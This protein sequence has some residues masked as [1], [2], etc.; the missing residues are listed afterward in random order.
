MYSF[1]Y[2]LFK[3]IM[4]PESVTQTATGPKEVS[5]RPTEVGWEIKEGTPLTADDQFRREIPRHVLNSIP[6]DHQRRGPATTHFWDRVR[7][8][9]GYQEIR[10][11]LAIIES[12]GFSPEEVGRAVKV[13]RERVGGGMSGFVNVKKGKVRESLDRSLELGINWLADRLVLS[14]D[15]FVAL[16]EAFINQN[17]GIGF[18]QGGV[19]I[20]EVKRNTDL[21]EFAKG[22]TERFV[23][24]KL[25]QIGKYM[26]NPL[27]QFSLSSAD[28][29]DMPIKAATS[30]APY[31]LSREAYVNLEYQDSLTGGNM[32]MVSVARATMGMLEEAVAFV[33]SRGNVAVPDFSFV[34]DFDN[35]SRLAGK[36]EKN[37]YNL[38]K[39]PRSERKKYYDEIHTR[40][41]ETLA[42]ALAEVIETRGQL[43]P[44]EQFPLSPDAILI[45]VGEE[46]LNLG[47]A[48]DFV[49]REIEEKAGGIEEVSPADYEVEDVK[50]GVERD[51][52]KRQL[53]L[54]QV[55]IGEALREGLEYVNYLFGNV[56][57][58]QQTA[59][60]GDDGDKQREEIIKPMET[61]L[62]LVRP[63]EVVDVATK[64]TA[65]HEFMITLSNLGDAG[66]LIEAIGELTD[67]EIQIRTGSDGE[68]SLVLDGS[69]FYQ[70][71][72]D[73]VMPSRIKD[74]VASI[75][76]RSRVVGY[77]PRIDL[78]ENIFGSRQL[79][80]EEFAAVTELRKQVEDNEVDSA[81]VVTPDLL[82]NPSHRELIS[83]LLRVKMVAVHPDRLPLESDDLIKQSYQE[84]YALLEAVK[85]QVGDMERR[86]KDGESSLFD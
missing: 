71:L 27:R 54:H 80:A 40:A 20:T 48:L 30:D 78:I 70:Y 19:R 7:N 69:K 3:L 74:M 14:G 65:G 73:P 9:P 4:S 77:P 10:N 52:L 11:K 85:R 68:R 31:L 8:Y 58:E 67:Q 44:G 82:K 26:V 55:E 25:R 17:P 64:I 5:I 16:A 34:L 62:A 29:P 53:L 38:A 28:S 6:G 35:S 56:T 86:A 76:I 59:M 15:P 18:V 42:M 60:L 2:L 79:T 81:R 50:V 13:R 43:L 51:Q 84:T 32:E 1:V 22:Q 24:G 47:E 36:R 75:V 72:Q 66:S 49:L 41:R 57:E 46:T 23:R 12:S 39:T 37:N 83:R 33:L 61:A 63:V 21:Y 45:S